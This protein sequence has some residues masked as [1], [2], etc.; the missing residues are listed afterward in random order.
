MVTWIIRWPTLPGFPRIV[1]LSKKKKKNRSPVFLEPP[2]S[3]QTRTLI[4]IL[5]TLSPRIKPTC[6]SLPC[7]I[8][9][10]E[11]RWLSSFMD[12]HGSGLFSLSDRR[13]VLLK[14][15]WK[16]ITTSYYSDKEEILP[17]QDTTVRSNQKIFVEEQDGKL[18]PSCLLGDHSLQCTPL[19]LFLFKCSCKYPWELGSCTDF[20]FLAFFFFFLLVAED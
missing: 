11:I 3:R 5:D 16:K 10:G 4:I 18:V 13:N 8:S 2:W 1:L 7:H 9:P 14:F 19:F 15:L 6:P 17:Y 12:G 20:M